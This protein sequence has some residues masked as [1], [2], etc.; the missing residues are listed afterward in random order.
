MLPG[1]RIA[2]W[3]VAAACAAL[4]LV[5]LQG[6]AAAQVGTFGL[7]IACCAACLFAAAVSSCDKMARVCV[8]ALDVGAQ[9]VSA[10]HRRAEACVVCET[11]LWCAGKL[12]AGVWRRRSRARSFAMAAGQWVT[13]TIPAVG[14]CHRC[15]SVAPLCPRTW[16]WKRKV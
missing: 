12:V 2:A 6:L 11:L 13:L 7:D 4:L 1:G 9:R 5:S 8:R 15:R 16:Q 3:G 10:R 14:G